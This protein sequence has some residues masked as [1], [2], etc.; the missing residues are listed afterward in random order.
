MIASQLA[1]KACLSPTGRMVPACLDGYGLVGV[2]VPSCR[3]RREDGRRRRPPAGPA[4]I[5]V[6]MD[7][8]GHLFPDALGYLADRLDAVH[9]QARTDLGR[10]ER[11]GAPVELPQFRRDS[12][13]ELRE[14]TRWP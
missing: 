11:R 13:G 10:I 1:S 4:L 7:R 14:L 2:S 5:Q 12:G 6:T 3:C 9:T 8:Y